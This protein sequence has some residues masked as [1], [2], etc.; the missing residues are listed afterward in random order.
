M[1]RGLFD[2]VKDDP[3][4]AG[5]VVIAVATDRFGR[6]RRLGQDCVGTLALF[7]VVVKDLY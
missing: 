6:H 2:H 5:D 4:N 7:V 1:R 3:T